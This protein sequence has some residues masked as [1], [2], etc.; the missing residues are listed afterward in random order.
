MLF[1]GADSAA[2]SAF[3]KQGGRER[4]SKDSC[5]VLEGGGHRAGPV[6]ALFVCV[7]VCTCTVLPMSSKELKKPFFSHCNHHVSWDLTNLTYSI[8][9]QKTKSPYFASL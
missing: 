6:C 1:W 3:N 5:T 9:K 7:V 4:K 8:L 2:Y